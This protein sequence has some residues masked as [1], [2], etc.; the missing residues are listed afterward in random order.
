MV[1]FFS[2]LD[3]PYVCF[4]KRLSLKIF[5]NIYKSHSHAELKSYLLILY[6]LILQ[7]K[8]VIRQKWTRFTIRRHLKGGRGRPR[9]SRASDFMLSQTEV[10]PLTAFRK[11]VC[12][13]LHGCHDECEHKH[14][15]DCDKKE[16]KIF[17]PCAWDED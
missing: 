1:F 14:A 10:H 12:H 16:K 6:F 7:V 8:R 3:L 9:G 15:P 2:Y 17:C 4:L 11:S 5:T 13:A